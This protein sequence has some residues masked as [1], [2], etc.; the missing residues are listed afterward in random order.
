MSLAADK[1]TYTHS[2]GSGTLFQASADFAIAAKPYRLYLFTYTISGVSGAP[3]SASIT[4]AFAAASRPLK[5]KADG[6]YTDTV[7]LHAAA[8]PGNFVIEVTSSATGS[9]TIDSL[10]LK[11]VTGG[12]IIADGLFTGGGPTGIKVDNAGNVGI[13]ESSPDYK[14]DVNG[15]FGFTPGSSV[16]PVDNGDVIF[17]LTNNTTLTIKA[18]GSDGT[19]RSGTI[20]LA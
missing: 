16:T 20:T 4:T 11:E 3:P 13:G 19:V 9:F 10:S 17:E 5:I 6:T 1:A 2:T 8:S 18:K 14:L 15:A 12:D 7:L